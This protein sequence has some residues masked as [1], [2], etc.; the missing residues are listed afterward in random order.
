MRRPLPT[1]LETKKFK[2][3]KIKLSGKML[4][5]TLRNKVRKHLNRKRDT[6]TKNQE[7]VREP[8]TDNLEL[9]DK[10]LETEKKVDLEREMKLKVTHLT[11]LT[12]L[13]N[14]SIR[15]KNKMENQ[16]LNNQKLKLLM[17]TSRAKTIISFNTN[18]KKKK[19]IKKS[20]RKV[21][22]M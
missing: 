9:E 17:S 8:L 15:K 7:E 13:L 4:V 14:K 20:L 5:T 2:E 21:K 10:L 19:K 3:N 16:K 11:T 6:L 12:K 1:K 18:K 22:P